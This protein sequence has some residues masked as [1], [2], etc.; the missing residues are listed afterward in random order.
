MVLSLA[1]LLFDCSNDTDQRQS[2]QTTAI[3][4]LIRHGHD[5]DAVEALNV[6]PQEMPLGALNDLLSK[7]ISCSVS[8]RRFTQIERGLHHI[9][10]FRVSLHLVPLCIVY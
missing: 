1:R 3:G 7:I 2:L 10:R 9:E 8:K 5:I 6:L 4:L